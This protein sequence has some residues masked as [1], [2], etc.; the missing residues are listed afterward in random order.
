MKID[1]NFN[2][3]ATKAY[4]RKLN[5]AMS[6]SNRRKVHR[7]AA[8]IWKKRM[9]RRTPKRWTGQTSRSWVI[10]RGSGTLIELVNPTKVMR[11]LEYGTPSHG[12]K[13]ARRLFIPLT[14]RAAMAGARGVFA[15]NQSAKAQGQWANYGAAA[16]GKKTK[17]KK[18]PFIFG[19]DFVLAKKVRGI[20]AMYLARGAQGFVNTTIKLLAVRHLTQ[21]LR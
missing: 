9:V 6:D 14:K 12:P 2:F 4:V 10:R 13:T 11:Y 21:K 5:E 16:A 15:A 7:E 19:R 3:E 20:R 1:V 18:A 8:E 17:K